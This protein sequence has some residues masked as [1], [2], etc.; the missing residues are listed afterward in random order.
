MREIFNTM[1]SKSSSN[2]SSSCHQ[3]KWNTDRC[4]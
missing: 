3:C 4:T 1:D 2:F